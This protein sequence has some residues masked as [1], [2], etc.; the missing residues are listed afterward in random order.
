MNF[1][2]FSGHAPRST[3]LLPRVSPLALDGFRHVPLP[4][5]TTASALFSKKIW[6]HLPRKTVDYVR[7]DGIWIFD[8]RDP[9]GLA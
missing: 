5:P 6:R 8:A 1:F 2:D 9:L 4:P 3:D 7:S